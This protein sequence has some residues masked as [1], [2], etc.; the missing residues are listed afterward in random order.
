MGNRQSSP[1]APAADPQALRDALQVL[2]HVFT[3]AISHKEKVPPIDIKEGNYLP[4]HD[5]TPVPLFTF[6]R[7]EERLTTMHEYPTSSAYQH[8]VNKFGAEKAGYLVRAYTKWWECDFSAK[9]MIGPVR[10]AVS[11]LFNGAKVEWIDLREARI[12]FM[13]DDSL[14]CLDE[15]IHSI[16]L[17]TL[18][19]GDE[20]AVDF[21]IEQYGWHPSEFFLPLIE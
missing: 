5:S 17:I 2:W 8:I 11:H 20:L 18:P 10:K 19:P 4:E 21:T 15:S 3:I 12:G 9:S 13:V 6:I 1:T 16:P 7:D 14:G